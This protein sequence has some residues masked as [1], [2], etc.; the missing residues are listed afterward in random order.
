MREIESDLLNT[1]L[2][3]EDGLCDVYGYSKLYTSTNEDLECLFKCFSVKDKEVLSVL[4]SS[5]QLFSAYYHGAKSVNTFDRNKLAKY[6]YYLRKWLLLYEGRI[7]VTSKEMYQGNQW[8]LKLLSLVKCT[9]ADEKKAYQYWN[10]FVNKIQES[11][12]KRIFLDSYDISRTGIR[13]ISVLINIMKDKKLNFR[14]QDITGCIDKSKKYN[15]IILSNILEYIAFDEKKLINSRDNLYDI[16]GDDGEVICTNLLC[17]EPSSL[18]KEVFENKFS[19]EEFQVSSDCG[20]HRDN[21]G[22]CFC[23]K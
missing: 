22:Y 20:V 17:T 5:D 1:K 18:V 11:L 12:G 7:Y 3:V 21:V 2:V 13:D 16:L 19:Y 4:A 14:H 8:L 23:K 9:S 6:Y 15:T 10:L